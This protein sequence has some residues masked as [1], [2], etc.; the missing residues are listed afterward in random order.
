MLAKLTKILYTCVISDS[1]G[2]NIGKASITI[3]A[4]GEFLL[5]CAYQYLNA[6]NHT[7]SAPHV[8]SDNFHH[9]AS[10]TEGHNLTLTTL[11]TSDLPLSSGYP[12]WG[13]LGDR[14]L[15]STAVVDNYTDGG[16]LH[17]RLSLYNLSYFDDSGNY[18]N[19]ASNKC[20][21]SFIFVFIQ[22]TKGIISQCGIMAQ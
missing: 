7:G 19:T 12:I 11:V 6:V 18:T 1:S 5:A 9:Y 13:V 8:V 15:P 22:V 20:G 17:S 10:E 21:T 2:Q 4:D 16:I 3:L 14:S